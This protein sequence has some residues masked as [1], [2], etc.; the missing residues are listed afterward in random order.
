[1]VNSQQKEIGG[2]KNEKTMRGTKDVQRLDS[3]QI[4][5][6]RVKTNQVTDTNQITNTNIP[7]NG[8]PIGAVICIYLNIYIYITYINIIYFI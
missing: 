4:P 2:K 7:R 1:M 8:Y 3:D 6:I 5:N